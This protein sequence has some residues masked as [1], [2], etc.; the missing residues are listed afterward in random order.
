MRNTN[1]TWKAAEALGFPNP[2]TVNA[3]KSHVRPKRN[4]IPVILMRIFMAVFFLF[5]CSVVRLRVFRVCLMRTPITMIKMTTLKSK[6]TKMGPRKLAKNTTGSE[7]KQ[8]E[9]GIKAKII[10]V[11]LSISMCLHEPSWYVIHQLTIFGLLLCVQ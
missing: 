5:T 7:M 1:R 4:I 2:V 9:E 6:M 8:L 3:P 10:S 11:L